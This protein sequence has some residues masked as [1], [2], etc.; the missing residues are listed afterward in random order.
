MDIYERT[1]RRIEM[2]NKVE[3]EF[4][5]IGDMF[6]YAKEKYPTV[7]KNEKELEGY[8]DTCYKKIKR[9]LDEHQI[10]LLDGRKRLLSMPFAK[11]LID[12]I[13]YDYFMKGETKVT[14]EKKEK[15]EERQN[16]QRKKV[17]ED[18]QRKSAISDQK[19]NE[20]VNREREIFPYMYIEED[21]DPSDLS[22]IEEY[23]NNSPD[24]CRL[25]TGQ[26]LHKHNLKH[27]LP[28]YEMGEIPPN[29]L[30]HVIDRMMLRAVFDI[31][32]D[33]KEEDFRID[34]YERASHILPT[35]SGGIEFADGYSELTRKLENPIGNYV[36]PKE[37]RKL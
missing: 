1:Y 29:F 2:K 34:F 32:Y 19:M 11:Y 12:D 33:F 7:A 37:K 14:L 25:S 16:A 5:S 15:Y 22:Y 31:F 26:P 4:W 13:L 30:D 28:L 20:A 9:T 17:L 36:F 24:Y 8:Q 3:M 35:G 18:M 21:P 27:H 10:A 6:N 23:I